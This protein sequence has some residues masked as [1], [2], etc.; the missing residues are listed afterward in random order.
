MN[1]PQVFQGT[2]GDVSVPASSSARD[3]F[4]GCRPRR[5][6]SARNIRPGSTI[7]M[8]WSDAI[9][10]IPNAVASVA[11]MRLPVPVTAPRMAAAIRCSMPVVSITPPNIIAERI[12]QTVVNMLDM[13][14]RDSSSSSAALPEADL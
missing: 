12:S 1:A 6:N 4:F 8:Y 9:T 3:R 7:A 11:A 10:F 5:W 13:P 2:S 14:P